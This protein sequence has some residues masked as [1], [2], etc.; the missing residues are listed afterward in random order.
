MK[1]QQNKPPLR[2]T[3]ARSSLRAG[4]PMGRRLGQDYYN[5]AKYPLEYVIHMFEMVIQIKHLF[6]LFP[7]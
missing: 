5:L 1:F 7:A 4:G 6:N 3:K 2:I